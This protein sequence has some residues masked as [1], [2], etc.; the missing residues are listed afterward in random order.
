MGLRQ[1]AHAPLPKCIN[2]AAATT[3]TAATVAVV[4]VADARCVCVFALLLIEI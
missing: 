4:D 2:I 1:S 3:A